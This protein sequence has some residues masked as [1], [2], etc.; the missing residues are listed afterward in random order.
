MLWA[1]GMESGLAS[2]STGKREGG[3]VPGNLDPSPGL[4]VVQLNVSCCLHQKGRECRSGGWD[5]DIEGHVEEW[6][7]EYGS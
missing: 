2:A 6:N 3:K 7:K 1:S 5:Q 4:S